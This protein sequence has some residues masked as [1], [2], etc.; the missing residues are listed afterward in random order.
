MSLITWRL[1]EVMARHKIQAGALAADM[2]V[3]QNAVTNWRKSQ[4]PQINSSRL[5]A[6]LLSLNKLSNTDKLI[7]PG[8]LISFS[9][10]EEEMEIIG[11]V[12]GGS[13][14]EGDKD[15]SDD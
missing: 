4:M 8:D 12:P 9:L 1:K 7:R 11:F 15:A 5:N 2:G 13:A 3:T 14:E 6:I 10:T